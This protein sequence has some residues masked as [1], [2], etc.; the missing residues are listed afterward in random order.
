M[1]EKKGAGSLYKLEDILWGLVLLTIPVTSFR[2]FPE[3]FRGTIVQPLAVVPL[4]L[5][6]IVLIYLILKSK[7]FEWP[8]QT[9]QLFIFLLV[10]LVS[11]LLGL[12]LNPVPVRGQLFE[13]RSLKA[14]I[15]LLI[16]LAFFVVTF[17]QVGSEERLRRS[18]VWMFAGLSI[19]LLWSG[20]QA[21]SVFTPLIEE[22]TMN[23]IQLQFSLRQMV[24]GRL[25]GL[26]YEPSWLAAQ[27]TILFFPWLTAYLLSS[28][29]LRIKKWLAAGLLAV[30]WLVLFL[31]Y[32]RAGLLVA[33]VSTAAAV[34][35]AGGQHIKKGLGW[36][37]KPFAKVSISRAFV[38]RIIIVIGIIAVVL[39]G[40]AILSR[41]PYI[42]NLWTVSTDKGIVNYFIDNFAGG[43][44]AY[45]TAGFE[46]FNEHPFFGIG[47]GGAGFYMYDHMPEWSQSGIPEVS[48]ILTPDSGIFLNVKSM[49]VRL[50]AE[51]GI[52]GLFAFLAFLFSILASGLTFLRKGTAFGRFIGIAAL[53]SWVAL[54]ITLFSRESLTFPV[55]WVSLGIIAGLA[56]RRNGDTKNS[57]KQVG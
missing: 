14:W 19:T 6:G 13:V 48:E 34:L 50:L 2:H 10:I 42:S 57:E 1:P 55:M 11:S 36:F 53:Q 4:A 47:L 5:L 20:L 18:M 43:R 23:I 26:A 28:Y 7:K 52:I 40:F 9:T 32:S 12:F 35:A 51:T 44:L 56:A 25:S 54:A 31:T 21:L 37:F 27:L 22:E 30:G 33:G 3:I 45:V 38:F 29:K 39:V 8:L 15:S 49:Y 46:V 16:G 41:N 24:N 17:L